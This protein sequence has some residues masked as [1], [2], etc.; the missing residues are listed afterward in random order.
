MGA[1]YVVF[2]GGSGAERVVV[3][4]GNL[5]HKDVADKMGWKAVS[6]GTLF[7][8]PSGRMACL[9][10]S[11]TLGMLDSRPEDV[12]L[13]RRT[14]MGSSGAQEDENEGVEGDCAGV[15][16][17]GGVRLPEAEAG[18]FAVGAGAGASSD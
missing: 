5:H 3:F 1:K 12:V 11:L 15:G 9:G 2:D 18:A 4:D 10:G 8:S 17:G 13:V 6:A 7:M 14:L 16:A